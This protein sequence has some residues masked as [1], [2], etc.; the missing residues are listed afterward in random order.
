M[1]TLAEKLDK[2]EVLKVLPLSFP[3]FPFLL[4]IVMTE[5]ILILLSFSFIFSFSFS[6]SSSE[7]R[8]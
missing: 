2:A 3:F 8:Q 6:L 5:G 4:S 7:P 1:L